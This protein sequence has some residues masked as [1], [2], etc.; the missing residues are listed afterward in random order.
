[1]SYGKSRSYRNINIDGEI[2]RWKVG[3]SHVSIRGPNDG[4]TYAPWKDELTGVEDVERAEWKGNFH[5]TPAHIRGYIIKV[6]GKLD[7]V[8]KLKDTFYERA[9]GVY[10]G[11]SLG[12]AIDN[13]LQIFNV[14][15][16]KTEDEKC[17][18]ALNYVKY[19]QGCRFYETAVDIVSRNPKYKKLLTLALLKASK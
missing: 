12:I 9:S 14:G 1:M 2:W 7:P 18:I 16:G 15:D 19:K 4:Q 6:A 10:T 17:W 3:G 8:S 5:V 11:G 13:Q